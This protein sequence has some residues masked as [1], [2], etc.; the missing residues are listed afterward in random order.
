MSVLVNGIKVHY[1]IHIKLLYIDLMCIH[2]IERKGK[3]GGWR[4]LTLLSKILQL[5][6]LAVSFIGGGKRIVPREN[7]RPAT[8]H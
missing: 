1:S 8:S 2:L 4:Y 7:H 5:N 3:L 6:I